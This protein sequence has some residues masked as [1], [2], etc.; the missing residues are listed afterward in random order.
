MWLMGMRRGRL[1][2]GVRVRA[3]RLTSGMG[4]GLGRREVGRVWWWCFCRKWGE[5]RRW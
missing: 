3:S 5:G 2:G 1:G 4:M